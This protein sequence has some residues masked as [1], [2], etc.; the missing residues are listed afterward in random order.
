MSSPQQGN[1]SSGSAQ[2]PLE[3]GELGRRGVCGESSFRE[4]R[5]GEKRLRQRGSR[6][7]KEEEADKGFSLGRVLN[8]DVN[9]RRG[10]GRSGEG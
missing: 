3:Q 2:E 7:N 10:T 6:E 8:A 1:G 5:I 4:E 9:G